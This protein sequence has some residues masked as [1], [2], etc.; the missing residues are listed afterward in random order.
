M[1]IIV[2]DFAAST[3]GATSILASFYEYLVCSGDENE[4][5][6]FLSD[7]YIRETENIHVVIL[8]KEKKSRCRRLLFDYIYGRKLVKKLKPDAIFYLQNTFIHGVKVPQFAYMDQSIPFQ[9]ICNFS[10]FK[11][12]ERPYA[13][14]QHIIGRMIKNSCKCADRIIVQTNWMKIAIN[15]QCN[16]PEDNILVIPPEISVQQANEAVPAFQSQKFLYP[17]GNMVYKNHRCI[18]QALK[19]IDMD[20]NELEVTFTI[21]PNEEYEEDIRIKCVGNLP[22]EEVIKR[23]QYQ[24]L[25]FPSYVETYGLPLAEARRVGTIVLAADTEFAREVL[26]GYPN[27]Y[28][29]DPFSPKDLANLMRKVML[30]EIK[31]KHIDAVNEAS[32][33]GWEEVVECI[34]EYGKK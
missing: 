12:E 1:R 22:H 15:E 9:T 17:A 20:E 30:S 14:Y 2:N 8:D 21:P 31:Q 19:F 29:F 34:L 27:A 18:K 13:I 5:Y 4:W 3:G 32:K 33:K 16:V 24:T 10:F 7:H 26:D 11:A 25:L 23:L 6:F 28:F